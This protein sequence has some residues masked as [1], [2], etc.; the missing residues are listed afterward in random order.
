MNES[1]N[2]P[3]HNEVTVPMVEDISSNADIPMEQIQREDN[4]NYDKHD[5][6]CFD[7]NGNHNNN[8][9][10]LQFDSVPSSSTKDLKNIKSVTNQNVKI[11][12]SSSTNSVIEESSEP[13]ISKLENVNL[14]A[15]VGGSQTR[16]YLNTNVTP[17]LLAG[18]RL[19]AVQQPEDPLRVLGEYLIEQSNILKSG[20]KES[21][22]S[23]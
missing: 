10:N 18:M 23:K 15:T 3:Q 1:E 11:E 6:E 12:E 22:A 8:S 4:K 5:N 19:I 17:H 16:K 21:N 14:A 13:K 2:S 20:E 9:D 7:M